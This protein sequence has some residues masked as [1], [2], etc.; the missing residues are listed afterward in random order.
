GRSG[1]P[2][3]PRENAFAPD[4]RARSERHRRIHLRRPGQ[5]PLPLRR[6][7]ERVRKAAGAQATAHRRAQPA[8]E[9]LE[10][11]GRYFR[12]LGPMGTGRLGGE[13]NA[14]VK[15][16]IAVVALVSGLSAQGQQLSEPPTAQEI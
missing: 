14:I 9:T 12:S 5:L 6:R 4:R 13:M 15:M 8:R 10:L 3:G 7:A 2:A 11:R 1:A 16:S